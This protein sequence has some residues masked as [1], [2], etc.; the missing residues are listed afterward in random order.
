MV[1]S[2]KHFKAKISLNKILL[3]NDWTI[4]D[5][6]FALETINTCMGEREALLIIGIKTIRLQVDDVVGYKKQP[7]EIILKEIEYQINNHRR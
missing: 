6:E 1:E 4:I 2:P 3:E 5:D 7:L